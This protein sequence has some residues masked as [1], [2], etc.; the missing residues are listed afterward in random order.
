VQLLLLLLLLMMMAIE[1]MITIMTIIVSM[2]AY[3]VG[4]GFFQVCE[5]QST[6][7]DADHNGREVIIQQYDISGC[8][9]KW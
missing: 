7:L 1:V 2:K 4:D 6:L 9:N 8:V 3:R 5:E